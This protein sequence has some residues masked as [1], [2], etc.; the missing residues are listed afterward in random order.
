MRAKFSKLL[1]SLHSSFWFI[2]TLM[3]VLVIGLLLITIGIDQQLEADIIGNLGRHMRWVPMV[4]E[5]FS[6][7]SQVQ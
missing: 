4:H 1:D 3:A 5:L 6:L 7:R 2:P